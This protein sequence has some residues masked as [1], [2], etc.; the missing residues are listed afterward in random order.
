MSVNSESNVRPPGSGFEG[1]EEAPEAGPS[2]DWVQQRQWRAEQYVEP[3][4]HP[5][6]TL[7]KQFV[8]PGKEHILF[9]MSYMIKKI[10]ATGRGFI[11][12]LSPGYNH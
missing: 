3:A 11:F 10:S 8:Y 12:N 7:Q 5:V 9:S 1:S 2:A 6:G 4:G